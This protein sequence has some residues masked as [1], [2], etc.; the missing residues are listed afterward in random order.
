MSSTRRRTPEV[1]VVDEPVH[2][3]IAAQEPIMLNGVT[4]IITRVVCV[5]LVTSKL[6][7]SNSACWIGCQSQP[8]TCGCPC[9]ALLSAGCAAVHVRSEPESPGVRTRAVSRRVF[10]EQLAAC[11]QRETR[12]RS[13]CALRILAVTLVTINSQRNLCHTSHTVWCDIELLVS[14]GF[15]SGCR[16]S[17]DR[18]SS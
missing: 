11:R 3:R 13:E 12:P 8:A 14:A 4:S 15:N 2:S 18:A 6:H 1:A 17:R 16:R 9:A 10:A 7:Q 5:A